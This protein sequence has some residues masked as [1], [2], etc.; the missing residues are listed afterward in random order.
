MNEDKAKA[1]LRMLSEGLGKQAVDLAEVEVSGA[2]EGF[3]Y[4]VIGQLEFEAGKPVEF[5]MSICVHEDAKKMRGFVK[6]VDTYWKKEGVRRR[7]L[8]MKA[9][10][11]KSEDES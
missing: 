3:G 11:Y 8:T 7:T 1:I 6:A 9:R 5:C 10:T 2:H 4:N